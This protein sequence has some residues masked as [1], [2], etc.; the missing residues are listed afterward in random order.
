MISEKFYYKVNNLLKILKKKFF[1]MLIKYLGYGVILLDWSC[2]SYTPPKKNNKQ[3][4]KDMDG[5]S[6]VILSWMALRNIYIYK[7]GIATV[8]V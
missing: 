5:H 1:E 4:I 8:H 7:L 2:Y 3:T 6:H